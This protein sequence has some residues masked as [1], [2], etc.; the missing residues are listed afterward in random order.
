VACEQQCSIGLREAADVNEKKL[1]REM[2]LVYAS[3]MILTGKPKDAIFEFEA[4]ITSTREMRQ[5][6]AVFVEALVNYG[7]VRKQM[8]KVDQALTLYDE[9]YEVVSEMIDAHGLDLTVLNQTPAL[10][11]YEPV[12]VIG[13]RPPDAEPV[14][15]NKPLEPGTVDTDTWA[16]E[17]LENLYLPNMQM[18][19]TIALKRAQCYAEKGRLITALEVLCRA[20]QVMLRTANPLPAT[21]AELNLLLGRIHTQLIWERGMFDTWNW[22]KYDRSIAGPGAEVEVP[23]GFDMQKSFDY[24]GLCLRNCV[25]IASSTAS[26][27]RNMLRAAL[28]D[29]VR[30]HGMGAINAEEPAPP[31][32]GVEPCVVIPP[33]VTNRKLTAEYT[34]LAA[35]GSMLQETLFNNTVSLLDKPVID[36][37]AIPPAITAGLQDAVRFFGDSRIT[38]PSGSD[39][40]QVGALS[41]LMYYLTLM[42]ERDLSGASHCRR[43][44]I[45]STKLHR[46]LIKMFPKYGELCCFVGLGSVEG[47]LEALP[48]GTLRIQWAEFP[49]VESEDESPRDGEGS[50][51]SSGA[52]R[53][54]QKARDDSIT[55]KDLPT[56]MLYTLARPAPQDPDP[57]AELDT[58]PI[59]GM[60]QGPVEQV[61]EIMQKLQELQYAVERHKKAN[62]EEPL[63]EELEEAI[64]GG[65]QQVWD[66]FQASSPGERMP[67]MRAIDL[68]IPDDADYVSWIPMLI[69]IFQRQVGLEIA[70]E[71]LWQWLCICVS[72]READLELI[73]GRASP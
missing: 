56:T 67:M 14:D 42:R 40:M 33:A 37:S 24:A 36:G 8:G 30:L 47:E 10:L 57:E 2:H 58:R 1:S 59:L 60:V 53:V 4:L 50:R 63:G 21:V 11:D 25:A 35:T 72:Q 66:F 17:K 44:E 19:V 65:L 3:V 34:R 54:V 32:E 69:K 28:V 55:Q 46:Q 61:D 16:W 26:H 12:R 23:A 68:K 9:A 39:A 6:D 29:L 31:E 43:L 15:K 22:G 45:W 73:D 70:E 51:P 20:R 62:A 49:F 48:A 18:F 41:V 71:S 64:K 13:L 27:D 5:E 7:D 38:P 52:S